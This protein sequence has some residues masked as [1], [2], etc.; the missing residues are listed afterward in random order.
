[1]TL[2]TI[3]NVEIHYEAYP[4][5]SHVSA[6]KLV[7]IHGYLSSTFSFR[8]LIPL[9]T[10]TY[11]VTALDLPGFGKSENPKAFTYSIGNYGKLILSFMEKMQIDK[12][13]LVGHSMGGQVALQAA[14]QAP[15]RVNGLILLASSGYLKPFNR[16]LVSASYL[17]FF[18]W[19]VRREFEKRSAEEVL[20]EVVYDSSAIDTAMIEGYVQP[21][22]AEGFYRSL[23]GLLRKHGGDLTTEEL[24]TIHTPALL[25]WG[26]ED[27]IVPLNI[28]ERLVLDLPAAS[29]NVY[30]HTGHLLPEEKPQE[31]FRDIQAFLS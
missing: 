21:M 3:D 26:R 19:I 5:E 1:M 25:L 31:I 24:K 23:L 15:G 13:V 4:C 2:M 11:S 30:E 14:K 17:P 20:R 6:E 28:G 18:T 29:L 10:Q 22:G 9:L 7:L 16:W 27:R 8:Q 12:A